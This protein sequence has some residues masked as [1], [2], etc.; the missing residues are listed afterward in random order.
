MPK[1]KITYTFDGVGEFTCEAE[2]QEEAENK[3]FDGD[4]EYITTDEENFEIQDV[5][6][7]N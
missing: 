2:D 5:Q 4:G 7:I 1:F 3:F 6:K